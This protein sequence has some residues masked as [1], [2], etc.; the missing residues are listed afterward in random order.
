MSSPEITAQL[1]ELKEIRKKYEIDPDVKIRNAG[2]KVLMIVGASGTGK[3]TLTDEV[4]LLR[5]D[6]EPIATRTTRNRRPGKDPK[7]FTTANEG[8]THARA[9]ELARKGEFVNF[10]LFGTNVYSTTP[11][12]FPD[13]SI[14]PITADS[15][16]YILNGG[17]EN[18]AVIYPIVD[19]PVFRDVLLNERMSFEDIEY[20][21]D[22]GIE[23]TDFA[24]SS[25]E[26][27]WFYAV[28]NSHE[29]GGLRRAAE[30]VIAIGEGK[31]DRLDPND[32]KSAIIAM[33]NVLV[34][35]KRAA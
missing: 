12:D 20:R 26:Q 11:E 6:I 5:P 14:G 35:L 30:N 7:T 17:F 2:K 32:A 25:V 31:G 10:S 19:A 24:I 4:F 13:F 28:E 15:V 27:P 18:A 1:A 33:R 3:S 21:L 8:F 29:G 22:E 9:L 34:D 23:S 16:P